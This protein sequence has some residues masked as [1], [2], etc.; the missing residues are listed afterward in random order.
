M[1]D[2]TRKFL[3]DLHKQLNTLE[4]RLRYLETY[5]SIRLI[6]VH[7]NSYVL[8]NV[9]INNGVTSTTADL[10][11]S[12]GI[13]TNANGVVL[14]VEGLPGAV[15][16]QLQIDSVQAPD[17]YSP[18][19]RFHASTRNSGMLFIALAADGQISFTSVGAN[20][21]SIYAWVTGYWI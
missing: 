2:P 4:K 17:A 7:N 20:I 21:S 9:T 8:N 3:D 6:T 5:D 18:L 1:P 15:T 19:I 16:C 11:G 13:P 10:R 14:M 12:Y